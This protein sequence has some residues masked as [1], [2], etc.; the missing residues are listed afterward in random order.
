MKHHHFLK[1]LLP[2]LL[3]SLAFAG[4]LSGCHGPQYSEEEKEKLEQN[5][6]ALMQAWLDGHVKDGKVLTAEADIYMYPSGPHYL[7]DF[8]G[9]TFTDGGKVRDYLINTQ[10]GAVYLSHDGELLSE[11]CLDY[12]FEKLGLDGLR[13]DCRA[14]SCTAAMSL[15]DRG[16]SYFGTEQDAGVWMPAEL[17]LSLE[18]AA[19]GEAGNDGQRKLLEDFVRSPGGRGTIGFGGSIRVPEDVALEQYNMEYWVKQQE[20]NGILF[21]NFELSDAFENIST[22]SGRAAYDRY[23]F[24]TIEDPDIRIFMRDAYWV[25]KIEK[26]GIEVTEAKEYDISDLK[27]EKT[28]NGYLVTFTDYDHKFDFSVYA[29][30]GSDF[31]K[32]EYHSHED[33]EAYLSPGSKIT[34]DRYFE[35]DLYW[36]EAGENGYLL[37]DKEGIRKLF[38]GGEELIPRD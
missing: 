31:L 22:Y 5:G 32:H 29:D 19:E 2:V 14:D 6:E 4:A 13:D 3:L 33:R 34:G 15:P 26:S 20:E 9:G 18:E 12:A 28:E 25:E 21:E 8:V 24:Q 35:E 11:V 30:E 17:T 37:T 36:K 16:N 7:T 1:K 10:T 38:F 27:F 23:C